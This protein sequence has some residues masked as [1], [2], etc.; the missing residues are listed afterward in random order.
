MI[1]RFLGILL[2]IG[3]GLAGTPL[4]AA[5]P[6]IGVFTGIYGWVSVTHAGAAAS[7]PVSVK[8]NVLYL[9][10]IETQPASRMRALLDDDTLL[11]LA[12]DSQLEIT[13]HVYDPEAGKRIAI[14]HLVRGAVR[15]L[16]SKMPGAESKFE[17][18][19]GSGIAA[20][21]G[22]YF[23]VW[24]TEEGGTGIANIGDEGDVA[25]TAVG[26]EVIVRPGQYSVTIKG[27]APAAPLVIPPQ[28]RPLQAIQL[29]EV[30]HNIAVQR[31]K[32]ILESTGG[33]LE[34]SLPSPRFLNNTGR[35]SMP[36]DAGTAPAVISGAADTSVPAVTLPAVISGA[37]R[38]PSMGNSGSGSMNSG[39]GSMNS[40]S[41]SINSG[42]GSI[43]SGLYSVGSRS[44]SNS[45]PK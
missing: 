22:T 21:R 13:E 15:A 9:D 10:L 8:D 45:C 16:V 34:K 28:G 38:P 17:V 30:P 29:T 36:M 14:L 31:P 44:G 4:Q 32:Q 23:V 40:D 3:I 37:V 41:G 42:P 18:H 35:S 5:S 20:A 12:E 1:H 39:P 6:S 25:F 26:E 24:V 43:S 33:V 2:G 7:L 19:T 11:S 27:T